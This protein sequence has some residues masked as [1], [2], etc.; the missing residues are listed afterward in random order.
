M[1]CLSEGVLKKPSSQFKLIAV[2]LNSISVNF[3]LIDSLLGDKMKG[4][5]SFL[6]FCALPS[7]LVCQCDVRDFK[8]VFSRIFW[9]LLV[10]ETY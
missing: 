4:K 10:L 8:V 1:A 9:G 2:L 3:H 6:K 5:L 7:E